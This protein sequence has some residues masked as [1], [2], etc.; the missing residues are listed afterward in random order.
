MPPVYPQSLIFTELVIR[1][2]KGTFEHQK[3]HDPE[4]QISNSELCRFLPIT[5]ATV[6]L[7]GKNPFV[8]I[9]NTNQPKLGCLIPWLV[10][11]LCSFYWKKIESPVRC[12]IPI[13][14]LLREAEAGGSQD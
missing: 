4:P 10:Q 13:I 8:M 11:R 1:L 6:A 7:C 14:P 9:S 5:L 3:S 2:L 12:H